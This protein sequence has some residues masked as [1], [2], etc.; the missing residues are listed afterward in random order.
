MPS[1]YAITF[2]AL[3]KRQRLVAGLT[4]EALADRAGLSPKAVSDLE[5]D[6]G[7]TPRLGTVALLADAL[8]LTPELRAALLA[9]ARPGD[10]AGATAPVDKPHRWVM[11][12]PLTPLIG[13]AGVAA[14][15]VELLRRGY[16]QLL[17]LTG[18]GGV[19]KTRV[20][21]EVARRMADDFPDGV[22]FVDLAPLRD[23]ALALDTIAQRLGVDE[24]SA[25]PL[26]DRIT[27]SLRDKRLLLLLDNFEHVLAAGD[28]V[29]ALL[30]ACPGV[31]VVVTSRVALHVRGGREYRIA[32]LAVPESVD[33]SET[34]MRSPAVE[35]FV[36]RA[37]GAAAE[38]W[39]DAETVSAVAQ[40]CRRLEG[41]PLA[42]ELAA[43]RVRLLPPP[44]LLARLDR[45]LPLLVAGP[46]D[47]PAR[48]K[49]MRDA[50]AWS[51]EL[52]EGSEQALF[53]Q[54]SAFVGGCTLDAAEAVC[55]LEAG[56]VLDGL[57]A[58]VD[59]S[60]LG[61]EPS[62]ARGDA[63]I[64]HEAPRVTL[65]ETVREYGLERLEAEGE[66]HWV[67]QRHAAHYL[68]LAE[69]AEPALR[70]PDAVAWL[71][72]LEREHD[73][74][75]VALGWA[76][77]QSD[78]LTALR[79]AGGVWRFWQQRGHISE[80]R[81]WLRDALCLPVAAGSAAPSTLINA[82]VGAAT[83][84]VDQT[85]FDEAAGHCE[86][87]VAL[88][89]ERG[90]PS[91]LVAALNVQGLFARGQD[92][93]AESLQYHQ[94]ALALARAA[95]DR[96]GEATALLGLAYVV[97][98]LGDAAQACDLAEE[99]LGVA[100]N[101]GDR[102]VVARAL[103]LLGW[104]ASNAGAYERAEAL[105]AEALDLFRTL[106][107][108]GETAGVLFL[109]GTV[110][111][112]RGQHKRA[113]TFFDETLMLDR[114]RGD[115]RALAKDLAGL[116]SALLNL[117]DAVHARVRSEESLSLAR[118]HDDQW[119]SAMSL[120]VLGHVE[121]ADGD[122]KRALELFGEAASLLQTIGNFMYLPWCLEG[123]AGVVTT[124]G[125]HE[126][127]AELDGAREAVRIQAGVLIAPLHPVGYARTLATVRNALTQ[128]AFRAAYAAGKTR[129]A[130][131]T[132]AAA[133]AD[134]W[135]SVTSSNE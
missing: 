24:R 46:R 120:T 9:A 48:Q 130:E 50:I 61:V 20:A 67:R 129:P 119:S 59:S 72:R 100:R 4:Q 52:L 71:A 107:D 73:N 41:L 114:D 80:G 79:L 132:L 25:A 30:E 76:R 69:Q 58:L 42:I 88:A 51:Y 33:S 75:R 23:P 2:G 60:L 3:L 63:D 133:L 55:G 93:Y 7:R 117:G 26:H 98:F 16:T 74:L 123:L 40:I 97:M 27:A 91:D 89:R 82:L 31:V 85:S 12:R 66:T 14:A 1:P 134:A 115:D 70:G 57:A 105:G 126:R 121:L 17:T 56:A 118:R 103:F 78:A 21:I 81:R 28:A 112:Y 49:T 5:R 77:E 128:D 18:P 94:E 22:V 62:A 122:D 44:V 11:P 125:Q 95:E 113:A 64:R 111:L 6:P 87:A 19:G 32:P 29:L 34:L 45:R 127:A 90:A 37:R 96:T 104:Q 86:H 110:A 102:H 116:G 68:A 92:R 39:L 101:L 36:E 106:E 135:S 47:L 65:L 35:L 131:Q 99:S 10:N 8:D 15:V 54:L 13:R 124:R 108:A 38:L 53:R 109:L 43:A 83:L 84:A